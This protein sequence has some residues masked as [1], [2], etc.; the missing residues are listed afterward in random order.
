MTKV[1]R[2]D[3]TFVVR[4]LAPFGA[5]IIGLDL[6]Q[7]ISDAVA[8]AIR[9][10]WIDAGIVLFRGAV[11]S[12][13]A[14]LRLSRCFGEPRPS[15][16][17]KLNVKD[18]PY[19]MNLIC[20]PADRNS[21]TFTVFEVNGAHRLARL[22][23]GPVVHGRNRARRGAADARARAARRQDGVH[24]RDRRLRSAIRCDEE[25]HRIAR[26]RVPLR[27]AAGDEPLR[28]SEGSQGRDA[29]VRSAR[30]PC[31]IQARLSAGRTSAR[32]HAA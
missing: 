21:N 15:A 26:G 3:M 23:L 28:L 27:G 13:D 32:H 18:N 16:T 5:E 8:E 25:A 4:P 29:R 30:S 2:A 24:R 20:G 1:R 11:T 19:L 10:V 9:R 22:A 31:S 12:A 7:P 6:E 14:H 17:A